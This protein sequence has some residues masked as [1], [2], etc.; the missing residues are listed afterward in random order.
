MVP[1]A[2]IASPSRSAARAAARRSNG[3]RRLDLGDVG[4]DAGVRLEDRRE[5]LRLQ[6]TGQVEAVDAAQDPIDRRDLVERA[7][8]RIISSSS[9]PSENGALSPK[10]LGSRRGS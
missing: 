2:A 1:A 4:A 3:K 9:T 10:C 5:E 7:A 8:S 6:P